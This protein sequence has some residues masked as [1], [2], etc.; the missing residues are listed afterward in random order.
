ML[1]LILPLIKHLFNTIIFTSIF[2]KAWK[3][4]KVIPIKKKSSSC[5]VN[6]LRPISLLSALSKAFEKLIKFQLSDHV[7]R[8]DLLHPLQSGFRKGHST[9]TAL[10]KVHDD[11]ARCIDRRG[12]AVLLLIDFSKAFDRVSHVKLLNK[13]TSSFGLSLT[14]VSL[15]DS[16][17]RDRFQTVFHNGFHS[18]FVEILSGVPQ[19]SV[20][21][22]LLFSLFI[23]DLPSV[24]EFCSVH[25]FAD[26]VQIY[27]CS[28]ENL[29]IVEMQQKMNSDL[30]KIQ[31]WSEHNFLPINPSKTKALFINRLKVPPNPPELLLRNEPIE[32]VDSACNLGV[33]FKSNL[34]WDHQINAQTRKIYGSLKQLTLTTKFLD[35]STKIKL[36]KSLLYP[37]FIF[38]DFIYQNATSESLNKLKVALNSCIRY[39]YNLSRFH[40]VSHLQKSLIGCNFSDFYQYRSCLTL[41]RIIYSGNPSYLRSK[42]IPLRSIRTKNYRIPQH[43]SAYYGQSLF[44][45]G[46]SNWNLLPSNIKASMSIPYFKRKLLAELNNT[47]Q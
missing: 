11:L 7:N 42:L 3:K 27:L 29:N 26:D 23:N 8:F 13:L 14:A 16:Y 37:H 43:N 41:F 17:L 6:N 45:R 24:L 10:I 34:D 32:Y 18:A 22:P 30:F 2:P 21:G 12:V 20:L 19:G 1:P 44:A 5:S 31:R 35:S 9:D 46:I 33:I 47:N 38:G 36:F 4:I 40:H 25:L 28:D 39:V 15:L